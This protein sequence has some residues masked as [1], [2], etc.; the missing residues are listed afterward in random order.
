M[1][2]SPSRFLPLCCVLLATAAWADDWP[3]WMGPR[4]DNVFQETGII[5]AIPGT[6]LP[7]LWR[8]P[9]QGGYAGP[10]V[11]AGK[12][13]L[14]DY[15]RTEGTVSNDP[16]ARTTLQGTERVLCFSAADGKPLWEHVYD[17][18]YDISY[19]AG[20]RC[21]PT[22]DGKR[23]YT[24][25][26][27]GDLCCLDVE[28]GRLAWSRNFPR[29]FAAPVPLW[30]HAAHPLIY[31]D[32]LICLVGGEGSVAVAFD[33]QTGDV[34]WK[35]LPGP[36]PGYCPP[37]LVHVAGRTELLIWDPKTLHSLDPRTGTV[38][39]TVPLEPAYGMSITAP[40][41]F[42]NLLF[43]SGIGPAGGLF[44]WNESAPGLEQL[45]QVTTKTGVSCANSTPFIQDGVLYGVDCKSGG[46]RAVDLKSSDWLWETYAP[47]TGDHR[48]GHGTAFMVRQGDR[49]FLFSETGDLILARLSREKYEEL[50]RFH[51]LEPTNEAF[52]R[53]VVWS[54]PAFAHGCCFARNDK[55]LV[56]VS[57]RK[58]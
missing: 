55:E 19:P 53:S 33:K 18:P 5:E 30:G 16:N 17:C 29:D 34:K 12:V 50:G 49:V 46:L 15:V 43:V 6:G 48:A 54:A 9:V 1:H 22:V 21:T 23:V 52:G 51:V 45:W 11:A 42:E 25:G 24:L 37:T 39:W 7:V 10:A 47:T 13:F 36:D 40:V 58:D 3:Q 14:M 35:S 41:P 38:H 32:L 27:E 57:L 56:C 26:A 20:P 31:D 44:K 4:R 8:T 2:N 28:T